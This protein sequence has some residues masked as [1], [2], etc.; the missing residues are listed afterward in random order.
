MVRLQIEARR[1][2]P[3]KIPGNYIVVYKEDSTDRIP[4]YFQPFDDGADTIDIFEGFCKTD[5]CLKLGFSR[6]SY[7]GSREVNYAGY[8]RD[9]DYEKGT[10]AK[11]TMFVEVK[12]EDAFIK[13]IEDYVANF[14]KMPSEKSAR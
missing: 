5:L 10:D 2:C 3:R 13:A 7:N 6:P 14:G 11:R 8:G 12:D 1:N 4:P 9:I